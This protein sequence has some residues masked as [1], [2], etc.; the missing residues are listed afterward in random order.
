MKKYRLIY[1]DSCPVC[2]AAVSKAVRLDSM[3]LVS[4]EPLSGAR[5]AGY[6]DLPSPAKLAKEIHLIAPDGAVY[7]GAEAVGRLASLFPRSK[8]LGRIILLPL[9]RPLARLVYGL[10]A[11]HRLRL[12][13]ALG[14]NTVATRQRVG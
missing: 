13:K 11:R 7:R 10:V 1:D 4:L 12:S 6:P 9:V 2:V 14:L 5:T 8:L 3:G